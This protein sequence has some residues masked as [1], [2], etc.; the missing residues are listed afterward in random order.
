MYS[1]T[2][3]TFDCDFSLLDGDVKY[4][5]EQD[6]VDRRK[7]EIL[8]NI[9]DIFLQRFPTLAGNTYTRENYDQFSIYFEAAKLHPCLKSM[10][11][12][13]LR[14]VPKISGPSMLLPSRTHASIAV[15][16]SDHLAGLDDRFS[17][18]N[19]FSGL[20]GI[21]PIDIAVYYDD[22]L[23]AFIEVDGSFHYRSDG[24]I[25]QSKDR[26]KECLYKQHYPTV[27]LYRIK[28]DQIMEVGPERAALALAIWMTRGRPKKTPIIKEVSCDT[29][30]ASIASSQEGVSAAPV[31]KKRGRPK[32][33]PLTS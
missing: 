16:L 22:E 10:I 21:F 5:S 14:Q 13:R 2:L 7:L 33:Q 29:N 1:L 31:D 32:K 18:F 28:R 6:K 3:M 24:S 9:H 30:A 23:Y 20:A 12:K 15:A 27:P 17:I 8:L 26:L 25:L 11:V 4:L 19:E